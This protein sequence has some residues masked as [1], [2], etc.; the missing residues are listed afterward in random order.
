MEL[1]DL[2]IQKLNQII[3]KSHEFHYLNN[4][5]G[6]LQ[7]NCS[8]NGNTM[9]HLYSSGEISQQKG[10]WAYKQ[11]SEF[12]LEK[13]ITFSKLFIFPNIADDNTTYV[14]L[15][16]DE[17]YHFRKMMIYVFNKFKNNNDNN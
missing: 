7:P 12:I 2:T 6:L 11:R 13:A 8:P 14:I 4:P 5:N 3:I 16:E 10:G 17:C 1:E 9:Y 15:T